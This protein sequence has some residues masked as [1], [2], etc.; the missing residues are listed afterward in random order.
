[1][2]KGT[3]PDLDSSIACTYDNIGHRLLNEPSMNQALS[4][5]VK[6]KRGQTQLSGK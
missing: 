4:L 2:V 3:I 6:K 1:M 5:L